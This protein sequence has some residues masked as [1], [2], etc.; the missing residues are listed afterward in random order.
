[1]GKISSQTI[2][3]Q[4]SNVNP[5]NTFFFYFSF[6]IPKIWQGANSLAKSDLRSRSTRVYPIHVSSMVSHSRSKPAPYWEVAQESSHG[7]P[8]PTGSTMATSPRARGWRARGWR[9]RL[10]ESVSMWAPPLR[11]RPAS[12]SFPHVHSPPRSLPLLWLDSITSW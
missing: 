8:T 12:N 6:I 4:I 1:M 9:A 5:F 3:D 11:T 2:F 10:L 7:K